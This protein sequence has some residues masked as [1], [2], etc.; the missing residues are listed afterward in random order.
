MRQLDIDVEVK[1]FELFTLFAKLNTP[2][3]PWDVAWSPLAATYP[4]LAGALVPLLRGTKYEARANAANRMKG[5]AARAKAWADL[6]AHLMLNDPPVA[7]YADVTH[8][9]LVSRRYG[10]WSGAPG[11]HA[12][13]R[14]ENDLD[15]LIVARG[16]AM[17]PSIVLPGVW[18]AD[19]EVPPS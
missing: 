12:Y 18:R 16:S 8:R 15:L 17:I 4:D 6:E 11:V 2:G 13:R 7:V 14:Q 9:G 10:C 1:P 3:E 5:A 19:V